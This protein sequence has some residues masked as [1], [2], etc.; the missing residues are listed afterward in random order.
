MPPDKPH[1]TPPAPDPPSSV[2]PPPG[3]E[4]LSKTRIVEGVII[5]LIVAAVVAA[6]AVFH[7]PGSKGA[8]GSGQ[9]TDSSPAN[10]VTGPTVDPSP[11]DDDTC[12]NIRGTRRKLQD[13]PPM[14]TSGGG[15][16]EARIQPTGRFSRILYVSPGDTLK[17]DVLLH[18]SSYTDAQDVVVRTPVPRG[19]A[20]CWRLKAS[21]YS[22]TE[23]SVSAVSNPLFILTVSG[24]PTHL[25]YVPGSTN[26][27]VQLS[28]I[29]QLADGVATGNGVFVPYTIPA[30]SGGPA[31]VTFELRVE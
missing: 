5:G 29:L 28:Q 16:L 17:V 13:S 7:H 10:T 2:E 3:G 21:A 9:P 6:V 20:S 18:D 19:A 30:G 26:F 22:K 24:K 8:Q 27:Y 4:G 15:M 25:V 23:K 14:L 12:A 11:N 1:G 31:W